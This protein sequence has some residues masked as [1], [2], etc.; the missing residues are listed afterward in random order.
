MDLDIM[1]GAQMETIL[2]FFAFLLLFL[3][4]AAAYA[5]DA[6]PI[7]S[8][9][10]GSSKTFKVEAGQSLQDLETSIKNSS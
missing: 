7:I 3:I 10:L 1:D 8:L 6:W 9:L 5:P 4:Y 2:L